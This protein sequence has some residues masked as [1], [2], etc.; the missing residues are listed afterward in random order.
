MVFIAQNALK[1]QEAAKISLADFDRRHKD[2]VDFS[3]S[4]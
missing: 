1:N 3:F 2:Q 4:N